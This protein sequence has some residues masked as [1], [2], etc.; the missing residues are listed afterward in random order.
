M[1]TDYETA[2]NWEPIDVSDLHGRCGF[3][4]RSLGTADPA[5]GQRPV[6]R[7][8]IKGRKRGKPVHLTTNGWLKARQ[9][10][11]SYFL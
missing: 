5:T 3:D 11:D 9:L 1:V 7:I 8:E 4:I 2:R 6:R 10:A